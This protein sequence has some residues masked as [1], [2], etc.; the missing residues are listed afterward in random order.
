[1]TPTGIEPVLP[2]WKGDV[3]TA[4]PRSLIKKRKQTCYI[5]FAN[6]PSRART[7]DNS[8]NSRVL[9]RLSYR[10]ILKV[11][12]VPYT[13]K[14]THNLYIHSSNLFWSSPRPISISQLRTLLYFHLWPINLV[15]FKGS[16]FISEW[17][18]LS[19][20]RGLDQSELRRYAV[21]KLLGATHLSGG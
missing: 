2:P 17:E 7:Y 6:S 5:A 1:M 3:L 20:G 21:F 15:V 16:Y 10:G 14:T 9:Y 18:I 8:V 13:F 4:W 12:S 11:Y 19:W